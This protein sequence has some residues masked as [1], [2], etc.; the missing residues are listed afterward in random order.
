ML[1]DLQY[2]SVKDP[3]PRILAPPDLPSLYS[4]NDIPLPTSL[5]DQF[6]GKPV[7]QKHGKFR[8]PS[9]VSDEEFQ[10]MMRYYYALITHIDNQVGNLLNVIE[11]TNTIIAFISDHGELLG[12]HGYTEN[13]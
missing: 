8:I 2:V 1:L 4:T 10:E 5:R 6:D 7:F 3:H 11:G 9:T 12:D 13:V